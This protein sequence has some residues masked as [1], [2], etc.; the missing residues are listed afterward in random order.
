MLVSCP[1]SLSH[2]EKESG[3][4]RI[5]LLFRVPRYWCGQSDCRTVLTS[6]T[7]FEKDCNAT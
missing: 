5:Q 1:D 3:E 2:V 4:T 7:L 6:R